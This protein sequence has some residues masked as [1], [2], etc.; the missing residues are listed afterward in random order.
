MGDME[1]ANGGRDRESGRD[2]ESGRER[3]RA[4]RAPADFPLHIDTTSGPIAGRLKDISENG[5]CCHFPEALRE[6]TRV[7][8][9]VSLPGQA[10]PARLVG[11]VV[12][13]EKLRGAAPPAYE[14]AVFF[15]ELATDTRAALQHFVSGAAT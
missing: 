10:K 6:M 2:L 15:T 1:T 13:C 4:P 9:D 11:A 14:V 3:R 8:V 7:G 12:R 5:L